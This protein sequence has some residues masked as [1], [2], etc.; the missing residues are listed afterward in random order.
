MLPEL[1][2]RLS[3]SA[4][5]FDRFG[6]RPWASVNFITSH[7]GFTL[8]DWASYN[9]KHNEANLEENRDGHNE[10][11]SWN[12]GI[13]GPTD[14]SKVRALRD[15]QKRN[16]L[17]T[18]LL[19]QGTPMLLAGDEMGRS[20]RGNNNAYCQDNPTSWVHW[21]IPEGGRQLIRFV[22]RLARLRAAHPA[23]R[24]PRHLHGR[25]V[26]DRGFKDIV[27]LNPSGT[28]KQADEWSDGEARVI[29]LLLDG[30]A[31]TYLDR[32]G[33]QVRDTA[34]VL[35]LNA[36]ED[37]CQFVLPVVAGTAGWQ[38]ALD[39]A[40]PTSDATAEAGAPYELLGRSLALMVAMEPAES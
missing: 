10:N 37:T 27:W 26:S 13:E 34:V 21:D 40:R 1:S 8:E 7:D 22:R 38:C 16:M 36:Q 32:L 5:L 4:D 18:L 31:G 14:D 11:Y 17:A 39:T 15:L 20:Q 19:S 25:Y 29:G 12:H 6:R 9:G 23:L 24:R 33:R 3:G 28:E 35:L 2:A 30:H